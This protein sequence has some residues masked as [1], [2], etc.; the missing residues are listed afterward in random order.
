MAVKFVCQ[1]ITDNNIILT[2]KFLWQ[3]LMF[4]L[5]DFNV[6]FSVYG[7]YFISLGDQPG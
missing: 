2:F 5:G 1:S 3:L 7:I 4:N 6:L